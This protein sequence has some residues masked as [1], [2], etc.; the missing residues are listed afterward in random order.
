MSC[1]LC[2][3]PDCVVDSFTPMKYGSIK[4]LD[5]RRRKMAEMLSSG[6]TEEAVQK[7]FSVEPLEVENCRSIELRPIASLMVIARN[8]G[9]TEAEVAREFGVHVRTVR[10]KCEFMDIPRNPRNLRRL[11]VANS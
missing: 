10:R 8:Q 9:K 6:W 5:I 7:F 11:K 2:G 1:E 4:A 3:W